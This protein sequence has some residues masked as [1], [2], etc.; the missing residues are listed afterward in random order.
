[1]AR[2][3]QKQIEA[4]LDLVKIEASLAGVTKPEQ[5]RVMNPNG[6]ST[7]SYKALVWLD[8]KDGSTTQ[9]TELGYHAWDSNKEIVAGLR[10]IH[11]GLRTAN[12]LR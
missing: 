10:G 7:S 3:T 12:N 6:Y 9:N 5:F 2:I 4:L 8:P 1:M 11:N